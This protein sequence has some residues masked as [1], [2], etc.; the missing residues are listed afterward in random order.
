[1]RVLIWMITV[2]AV[3]LSPGRAAD[4]VVEQGEIEGAKFAW[5]R[6]A[7]WNRSILLLAHGLRP[8]TAPLVADLS[9]SHATYQTFL[10]EGWIVAKTSY[11]R[12]GIIVADA[13]RDLE[14]L[15]AEIVRRFGKPDRVIVEGDSMGG[16][17]ALLIAERL[18]EL[19]PL[20]HGVVA[21]DPALAMRDPGGEGIGLSMQPQIPVVFLSSRSEAEGPRRYR[22][23]P[24]PSGIPLPRPF[25][26]RV[27]R[28]GHVN[29]NRAERL[30]ALRTLNL[31]LDNGLESLPK[32]PEGTLQ[33]DITRVPEPVPSR[34]FIDED[35]R[36][37]TA[38][39]TEVSRVFGNILLDVQPGDF[40]AIGLTQGSF[41]RLNLREQNFRVLLGK[42]FTSVKR[43]EW[44]SFLT[45]DGFFWLGR[46]GFN[47]AATTQVEVGDLVLVRRYDGPSPD[48]AL[49][50]EWR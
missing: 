41:F 25:L 7:R 24:M 19:D 14:N 23:M 17:I 42:D 9:P 26:L 37:F 50:S 15:R 8:E 30:L 5:A 2:C 34:V 11:R 22:E 1:M 3:L 16:L 10:N 46:N 39:V 44:V 40:A 36:G 33:V 32:P 13:I 28:D 4:V 47:A 21:V 20:F 31:W 38:H 43:G 12:N 45:A 48:P 18:P 27:N 6:P 35:R 49:S 29:V